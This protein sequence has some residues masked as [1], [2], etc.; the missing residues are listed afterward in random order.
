MS[1][2]LSRIA[3]TAGIMHR[4]ASGVTHRFSDSTPTSFDAKSRTAECVISMGSPVLRFYGTEV[5]RIS[6]EAVGLDRMQGGSII[7][8]LDT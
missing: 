7:P 8:L 5:L 2:I 1:Y 6:P 4:F 3:P